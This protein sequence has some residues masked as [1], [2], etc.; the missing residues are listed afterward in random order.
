[1]Q[2]PSVMVPDCPHQR[3]NDKKGQFET[4]S[5][6][7]TMQ[8]CQQV[9]NS[10]SLEMKGVLKKTF[11]FSEGREMDNTLAQTTQDTLTRKS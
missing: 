7:G 4:T 1:M 9:N 11:L 6:T 8:I 2:I 3:K 10:V 5:Q